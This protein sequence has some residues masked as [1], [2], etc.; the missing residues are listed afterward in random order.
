MDRIYSKIIENHWRE[1]HRQMIFL[2]GPRQSGKTTIGKSLLETAKAGFY[3][4]WDNLDH[5]L[6]I[7]EGPQKIAEHAGL[8]QLKDDLTMIVFDEIHKF[9][10]WKNFLKGFYDTYEDRVKI[11]VTGSSKLNVFKKGGDSLMGRY[12]PYQVHPL[13]LRETI[14]SKINNDDIQN[15]QKASQDTLSLLMKYGGFPEPFLKANTRFYNQW[16]K[17]R[18]DQMFKEDI[19]DLSR[20]QEVTQLELLSQLLQH[21]SGQLINYSKLAVKIQASVA[22]VKRWCEILAAFYYCFS[23]RPWTKNVARSLLKEPKI[24][25]WD[26]ALV[27]P[28]SFR[29]ENLVAV[30][31]FKAVGN[32]TDRGLGEYRLFFIRDKEKREV[33]FLISKNDEPWILVEAKLSEDKKL[34][35]TLKHFQSKLNVPYAFQTVYDMPYVNKDCFASK[36]KALIVPAKTFLSQLL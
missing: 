23:L 24:Y 8:D 16:K 31:L 13:T 18:Q 10:K 35:P 17:L 4:N 9:S 29:F 32:W 25:L 15:P 28:E 33:D 36:D 30:H 22:T 34:S 27:N 11:I 6:L 12:F 5:R 3:F 7:I 21:Q 19:R 26:W 1:N 14:N 20:V 2:S